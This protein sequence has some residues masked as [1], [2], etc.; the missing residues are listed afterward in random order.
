MPVASLSINPGD[1]RRERNTLRADSDAVLREAASMNAAI[2]HH[3]LNT[4]CLE[5]LTCWML[6]EEADLVDDCGAD[7]SRSFVHLGTGFKAKTAGDAT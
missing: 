2:A 1:R 4:F 7:K 6:I 5:G 3:R